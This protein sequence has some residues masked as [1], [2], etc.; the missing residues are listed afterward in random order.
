MIEIKK[1]KAGSV[2]FATTRSPPSNKPNQKIKTKIKPVISIHSKLIAIMLSVFY[3]RNLFYQT[4][5]DG[6]KT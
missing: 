4:F 6:N 1:I 2:Y 5:N 3:G